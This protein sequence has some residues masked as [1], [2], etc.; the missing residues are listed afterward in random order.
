[1]NQKLRKSQLGRIDAQTKPT[2]QKKVVEEIE[3]K[4]LEEPLPLQTAE[5]LSEYANTD[6]C[7]SICTEFEL[8]KE[9]ES[10]CQTRYFCHQFAIVSDYY[11]VSSRATVALSMLHCK[12]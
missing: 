3:R 6:S 12:T 2:V 7:G 4:T 11:R 9:L 5:C 10:K 1:M 8:R